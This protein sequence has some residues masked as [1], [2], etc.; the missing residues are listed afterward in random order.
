MKNL[1]DK[2]E[3]VDEVTGQAFFSCSDIVNLLWGD[4][5][6]NVSLAL[7]NI[8]TNATTGSSTSAPRIQSATKAKG[9]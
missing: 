2:E 3:E 8:K 5:K 6:I 9:L 4:F 1:Q 7:E